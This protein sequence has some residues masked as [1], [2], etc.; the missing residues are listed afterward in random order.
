MDASFNYDEEYEYEEIRPPDEVTHERLIEYNTCE[1]D[2][3][4]INKVLSLSM[5]EFTNQKKMN[6]LY[7]KEIMKNFILETIKRR[8]KF[9]ELLLKMNKLMKFDKD[10]KETYE[11][12]EPIIYTYCEQ[13]IETCEIDE[14]TYNKIFKSLSTVRIKSE[15]FQLLQSIIRIS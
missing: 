4:E 6:D 7:E 1:Y 13:Y 3:T 15:T 14:K 2:D 5:E 9:E 12:I 10:I 8:E 11:I